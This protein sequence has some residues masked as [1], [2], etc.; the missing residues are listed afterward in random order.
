MICCTFQILQL[1]LQNPKHR[2]RPQLQLFLVFKFSSSLLP[3]YFYSSSWIFHFF[4]VFTVIIHFP[5]GI[6]PE[7]LFLLSVQVLLLGNFPLRHHDDTWFVYNGLPSPCLARTHF[8]SFIC[9]SVFLHI[10]ILKKYW[11][12]IVGIVYA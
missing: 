6:L 9:S 1:V 2:P 12:H 4:E 11:R 3:S 8:I 5:L 7:L 10:L